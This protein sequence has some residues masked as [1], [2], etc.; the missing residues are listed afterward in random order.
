MWN[1]D[2]SKI[3][4]RKKSVEGK[5]DYSVNIVFLYIIVLIFAVNM[6]TP[7]PSCSIDT[8]KRPARVSF[9]DH[10]IESIPPANEINLN[11]TQASNTSLEERS[12]FRTLNKW[13]RDVYR[14]I[15][16][17]DNENNQEIE[18]DQ[19]EMNIGESIRRNSRTQDSRR[20]TRRRRDIFPFK[21][22]YRTI[23]ITDK[24]S[25]SIAC[26]DKHILLKQRPNLCLLDKQLTIIKEIQWTYD[27]VDMCWSSILDRF[28]LITEK[29]IFTLDQNTM[30]FNQ[31]QIH[32]D[33]EK[34]W[35]CG[36]CS[37][38]SLYLSTGDMSACLY[39]YTLRPTIE[40]VKIWQLIAL[41]STN[42]GILTFI[43]ANEKL[44]LIISN[45][46]IFQRRLD[47]RSTTTLERL[48]SI[49]LDA[50]AHCCSINDDQWIVME[51]LKPRLLHLSSDG[52]ILQE[53]KLKTSSMNI[54]WNAIQLDTDTIVTFTMKTLNLHKL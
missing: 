23:K 38:T 26:N 5:N 51:L 33:N 18:I 45:V 1:I 36:A 4:T 48:W 10:L 47:I 21:P 11:S 42:E 19:T 2:Q 54:I 12:C 24:T 8:G 9:N 34:E 28:I 7:P 40:F 17:S 49:R 32:I 13:C 52:K 3:D 22:P 27:H 20:T 14:S 25:V 50:V 44:A 39:E 46:Q 37:D 31:C 41:P 15:K 53:Y 29:I 35:S 6:T 30:T 16:R 43:Y